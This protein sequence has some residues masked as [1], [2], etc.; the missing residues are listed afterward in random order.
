MK[1]WEAEEEVERKKQSSCKQKTCKVAKDNLL[2][3]L[4]VVALG[5]GIGVGAAVRSANLSERE[6]MYFRFPGDLLMRMLKALIIPLITS[7]LISG[8]AGLDAKASGKLGLY[9]IVYYMSTTLIAVLLGILLVSTIKPGSRINIESE[10]SADKGNIADSFLD[11]ISYNLELNHTLDINANKTVHYIQTKTYQVPREEAVN[12][13]VGVNCTEDVTPNPDAI[14]DFDVRKEDGMNV[15]GL[16]VYSV[17][18]GIVISRLGE[19]GRPLYIFF[20]AFA[21]ATMVLVTAVIWYSPIGILF[22]V[23]SEI[24]EMEDPVGELESLGLYIATVMTGLA[25]HGIIILPLMYFVIVRKN[26]YTYLYRTLQ[27][28]LT[29]LGTASSSAT[30]PVTY[31]CLEENNHVDPRVTRFVLPVG[32]TINM[33]GTALYEAVAAIFIAQMRGIHLNAANIVAASITSTLASVGAAS[34]P[35]AGIVTMV[36]VLTALGLPADDVTKILAVDWMLDRFRTMVNVEGDSI[37]AGI[38]EH[39]ARHELRRTAPVEMYIEDGKEVKGENNKGFS[40]DGGEIIST[41]L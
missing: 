38:V 10:G 14:Y 20:N 30:L 35:Q 37:G 17:A 1:S 34:V 36:I 6:Q 24:I 16:V 23:A 28:L 19:I 29:A 31:R 25:I 15:L 5:L 21:E 27:A 8:L 11:L 40:K 7:S 32:A 12:I 2:L 22:L 13:T 26:P 9:A 3:I 4:L 39:L 41:G 33:D 18:M